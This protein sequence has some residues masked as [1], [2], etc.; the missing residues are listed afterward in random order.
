VPTVTYETCEACNAHFEIP[1]DAGS[2]GRSATL[3]V[4]ITGLGL[5]KHFE[6]CAD[7]RAVLA[8]MVDEFWKARAFARRENG[9]AGSHEAAAGEASEPGPRA[10][11][12]AAGS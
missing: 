2:P 11:A 12:G 1:P 5:R 7:C 4:V 10:R 8:G 6:L 9:P 3:E